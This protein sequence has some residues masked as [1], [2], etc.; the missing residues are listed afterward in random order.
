MQALFEELPRQRQDLEAREL[1]V[2]QM[3]RTLNLNAVRDAGVTTAASVA[4]NRHSSKEQAP[5]KTRCASSQSASQRSLTPSRAPPSGIK[6]TN[7][8]TTK[9]V[10]PPPASPQKGTS[11]DVKA[12]VQDMVKSFLT[13][14]GGLF[15]RRPLHSLSHSLSSF[16]GRESPQVPGSRNFRRRDF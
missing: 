2:Q 12:M 9:T 10:K 11:Q 14:L 13:Q 3:T 7:A 5:L 16:V 1:E 6:V 8:G 4:G 15:L